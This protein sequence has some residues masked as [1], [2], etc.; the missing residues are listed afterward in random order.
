MYIRF[1]FFKSVVVKEFL[2]SIVFTIL[3]IEKKERKT[4][5]ECIFTEH[6]FSSI[7]QMYAGA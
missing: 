5:T 4:N 1:F 2:Y 6:I 3:A 7:I